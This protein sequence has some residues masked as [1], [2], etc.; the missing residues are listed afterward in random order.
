VKSVECELETE[1]MLKGKIGV[2]LFMLVI[3][4]IYSSDIGRGVIHEYLLNIK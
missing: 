2:M 4:I 1:I 3:E